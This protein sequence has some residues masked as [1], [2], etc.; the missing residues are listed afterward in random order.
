MLVRLL[1]FVNPVMPAKVNP[2]G[3]LGVIFPFQL[4]LVLQ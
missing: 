3:K 4:A 2:V 1:S